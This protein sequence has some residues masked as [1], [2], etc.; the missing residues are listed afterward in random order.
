MNRESVIVNFIR[1]NIKLLQQKEFPKE[2]YKKI[3]HDF[4]FE[5]KNLVGI[6]KDTEISQIALF[7]MLRKSMIKKE[8]DLNRLIKLPFF[9][10]NVIK[11][12]IFF[13]ALKLR[14]PNSYVVIEPAKL[15]NAEY[16][17][18][19]EDE[20]KN[21]V[22]TENQ[23][24]FDEQTEGFK[25][26]IEEMKRQLATI[27]TR[28]KKRH[29]DEPIIKKPEEEPTKEWW[30]ILNLR[31]DPFPLAE[32][33]QN[34]NEDIYENIV[35]RTEIF[36]KYVNYI[37]NLQDQVFKNTIFYGEFGSGKTAFFDYLKNI[38]LR[39]QI[40]SVYVQLWIG[41]DNDTN[42]FKF[43]EEL[44]SKLLFECKRYEVTIN[45]DHSNHSIVVNTILQQ[46]MQQRGFTG[47]VIFVDDLHKNIKAYD[48]VLD[49]LSYLQIFTS[50]LTKGKDTNLV[51]YVAGI[52]QWK[53][54][55]D[56]EP[57]LSGSLIRDEFMPSVSEQNAYD[58]LNKRMLALSKN[59]NKKNIIGPAFVK[60]IYENLKKNNLAITFREFIKKALVEFRNN[61]FDRVLTVN[62]KAI[63]THVLHDIHNIIYENPKLSY[64]FDTLLNNIAGTHQENRQ[65]CF[66]IL[67]N[68]FLE[69]GVLESSP[70]ADRSLW[71]FQQL[72]QIGLIHYLEEENDVRWLVN[73]DL[74]QTNKRI[75]DKYNLSMEDYLI[76]A[77]LGRLIVK[78]KSFQ[79]PELE[80]L[81]S[82]LKHRT[83]PDEKRI[84][85]EVIKNYKPLLAIEASHKF[86]FEP[87]ELVEKCLQSLSS[88]TSAFLQFQNIVPREG[89]YLD[90]INFWKNF[91]YNTPTIIEFI[92]QIETVDDV[93]V[94]RANFIFGIYIEAFSEIISFLK[95]QEEKNRIFAIPYR[96]LTND[97]YRIIDKA[98]DLW[99]DKNYFEMCSIVVKHL[100]TKIRNDTFN[101]LTLIYG[102]EE[103]LMKRLDTK[104]SSKINEKIKKD[105][106]K[107]FSE[108]NNIFQHLDRKDYKILMTK[109]PESEPSDIG[110][111]NWEEVF[112]HIFPPW[113]EDHLYQFLDKFGDYNTSTSHNKSESISE[114]QQPDLRQFTMDSIFF[115]QRLNSCYR[116]LI[117]NGIKTRD[118]KFYL[119]LK[120]EVDVSS[121]SLI[122]PT[123]EEFQ[124]I[125]N[126]MLKMGEIV[127]PMDNIEYVITFFNLTYRKFVMIIGLLLNMNA[128]KK[129]KIGAEF[130]II[131]DNSPN[132][133]F[134]LKPLDNP[135]V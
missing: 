93:D 55:I 90:I 8:D 20:I 70:Q 51:T 84:L 63:S 106:K 49:F 113:T 105:E 3:K 103:N 57:R 98:R 30:Q 71:A 12:K 96:N 7:Y 22:I 78:Q 109:G 66:E 102:N 65:K 43:E 101:L 36:G 2:L 108:V 6:P 123:M 16:L 37:E 115:L 100:E 91:W 135:K 25:K 87:K 41:L 44:I 39:K 4:F 74:I 107:G 54:K 110:H 92:N 19:I 18:R 48:S 24:A 29:Y 67:G 59:Q 124:R 45:V 10:K 82:V 9:K 112:K 38:L 35:V 60:E 114:S 69:N 94:N 31:E 119:S 32:G 15:D 131:E 1:D 77:F 73:K 50:V 27:P 83:N 75:I 99:S 23:S 134:E 72:M 104:I 81:E 28:L 34:I 95:S 97:D 118:S 33:F 116:K 85:Q 13:E 117:K 132:F 64:Q 14:N 130:S 120:K 89:D 127:V 129:E 76:P 128:E 46:L 122:E 42:I 40:L 133:R 53:S 126:R 86:S 5:K 26:D 68:I 17:Q 21:K 11:P 61:N 80:K 125:K 58:M 52:P 47:F 62:P 88:L 111:K 121:Q 79:S 56:L